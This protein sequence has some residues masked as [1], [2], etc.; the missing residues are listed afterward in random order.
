[1]ADRLFGQLAGGG[2]VLADGNYD[3]TKLFDRAGACGYQ[4]VA[5]QKA[6]NS[7]TGHHYQS[8]YRLRCIALLRG[9]FGRALF[10]LRTG[11]ERTIGN[12]TA[13]AGGLGPLPAWVHRRHRVGQWVWAKLAIYAARIR[14]NQGLAACLHK[15]VRPGLLHDAPSGLKISSHHIPRLHPIGASPHFSCISCP[16]APMILVGVVDPSSRRVYDQGWVRR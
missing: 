9:A 7:G 11:I 3:A 4:L 15:V 14:K 16:A 8:P 5:A 2:Y 6:N 12:A 10:R 13:F 1:V